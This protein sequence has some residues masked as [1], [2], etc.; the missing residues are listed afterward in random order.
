MWNIR[1]NCGQIFLSR[2]NLVY[3]GQCST[4]AGKV[5]GNAAAKRQHIMTGARDG[6]YMSYHLLARWQR[7]AKRRNMHWEDTIDILTLDKMFE[8]QDGKC[9]LSGAKLSITSGL[10]YHKLVLLPNVPSADRIDNNIHYFENNMQLVTK[11]VNMAKQTSA[12]QDFIA[13]CT[14]VA[15]HN[16]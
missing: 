6:K 14:L 7:G 16:K 9:A 5:A 1:C 3:S 13:M 15:N 10:T 11:D 8:Q 12:Q 4:C 2:A